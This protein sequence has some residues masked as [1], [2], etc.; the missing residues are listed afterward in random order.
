MATSAAMLP[1]ALP[2][3]ACQ[4]MDAPT[5]A[6][7][8][9]ASE[10]LSPSSA[11]AASQMTGSKL[12]TV[13]LNGGANSN[14]D[15]TLPQPFS[16]TSARI[17]SRSTSHRLQQ[18]HR[19]SVGSRSPASGERNLNT[20]RVK[21]QQQRQAQTPIIKTKSTTTSINKTSEEVRLLARPQV[22]A[23][24]NVTA[25]AP[26]ST[27]NTTSRLQETSRLSASSQRLSS[28]TA[29]LA[30]YNSNAKPQTKR[31]A[32][33]NHNPQQHQQQPSQLQKQP[34]HR[35]QYQSL[36]RLN[37]NS[38]DNTTELSQREQQKT[39]R[40]DHANQVAHNQQVTVE[41]PARSLKVN[42]ASSSPVSHTI[43]AQQRQTIAQPLPQ[44]ISHP[45]RPSKVS[46]ATLVLRSINSAAQSRQ[47]QEQKGPCVTNS[48]V[49]Q[50]ILFARR[51]RQQ[52]GSS[53]AT[54]IGVTDSSSENS[55]SVTATARATAITNTLA[56]RATAQSLCLATNT[57]KK[58]QITS[59]TRLCSTNRR[60]TLAKATNKPPRTTVTTTPESNSKSIVKDNAMIL[61]GSK[62]KSCNLNS[63][64]L[65]L[66]LPIAVKRVRQNSPPQVEI[67]IRRNGVSVTSHQQPPYSR[68]QTSIG[69]TTA[70][71][72]RNSHL[73]T[74]A[75]NKVNGVSIS[76]LVLTTQTPLPINESHTIKTKINNTKKIS[77]KRLGSC[78]DSEGSTSSSSCYSSEFESS[79]GR[80][81]R[82]VG[83]RIASSAERIGN[84]R[85]RRSR[86]I[87]SCDSNLSR[88]SSTSVSSIT[89]ASSYSNINQGHNFER[90]RGLTR[91]LSTGSLSAGSTQAVARTTTTTA[92]IV[93]NDNS[94]DGDSSSSNELRHAQA[95]EFRTSEQGDCAAVVAVAATA[96]DSERAGP[97]DEPSDN[98][99]T[100]NNTLVVGEGKIN[101]SNLARV[102]E[103]PITDNTLINLNHDRQSITTDK[104][105][106]N[107]DDIIIVDTTTTR[108]SASET[109]GVVRESNQI[110][111]KLVDIEI[112]CNAYDDNHVQPGDEI[113]TNAL[114]YKGNNFN[115]DCCDTSLE[116][117]EG[118]Q[119]SESK[120]IIVAASD[121]TNEQDKSISITEVEAKAS[122]K[123]EKEEDNNE[124]ISCRKD[125]CNKF[126]TT[127]LAVGQNIENQSNN[128]N[129]NMTVNRRRC[130]EITTGIINPIGL[131]KSVTKRRY[132]N[133]NVMQDDSS[134]SLSRS[135]PQDFPAAKKTSP[136]LRS[137]KPTTTSPKL[138]PLG[139]SQ[140]NNIDNLYQ[141]TIIG[142]SHNDEDQLKTQSHLPPQFETSK[143]EK[144]EQVFEDIQIITEPIS[145]YYHIEARPFARGKF[146]QVKRC[147]SRETKE[148]FA[149]KCIKKR[150][151]LVDIR[152]EILLEIEALKLSCYT[153]HIVK[154]YQ[155]FETQN[156]MILILE[157]AK[158]GE[159]QRVLDDEETIDELNVK[160]MVRQI[161]EGLVH[162]HDNEI[163]HLDIKPQNLLLTKSFP[164]GDIKLCDF[165][166]SRRISRDCEIREICGTPDYVAPEILRYDPISLATDMWS[167][168]VLTYV[169]LSGYSPFGSE[170]KQQTFCNITQAT[171]DFPE[172][173]FDK[174]SKDAID[175]MSKLIVREPENRLTSRQACSHPWLASAE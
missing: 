151:R 122:N 111:N 42:P 31:L 163:A 99:N 13:R 88:R 141:N 161:L 10:T 44:L 146:A 156:E 93:A 144:S 129:N 46:Q 153:K 61:P 80:N 169:L 18:H 72:S 170:N 54:K 84:Q 49:R 110:A 39:L 115:L 38:A 98:D 11:A 137:M 155:V 52:F 19:Q 101:T 90:S 65:S 96:F 107:S 126:D 62:L 21:R 85:R 174:I 94:S 78:D 74:R 157:M 114:D 133:S 9:R 117:E 147:V 59:S 143:L 67:D 33:L 17:A 89:S 82:L 139:P 60:S 50:G 45:Q 12:A 8:T 30:V 36:T 118:E 138:E 7:T 105:G 142:T 47:L 167:L 57:A 131:D 166:I 28:S 100:S 77:S 106:S 109:S 14:A 152:H 97:T 92:P 63:S 4:L 125:C 113:V 123:V 56:T 35:H 81:S 160:R 27:A 136:A 120:T 91:K 25:A 119:E 22:V 20:S 134:K 124:M 69:Q 76:S 87:D 15:V 41:G 150:R 68:N 70:T 172:E 3:P 112:E 103:I 55:A 102:N 34:N 73:S 86:S 58:S 135:P 2:M 108:E 95:H 48:R 64:S 173:I 37:Q 159:L 6:T 121:T 75:A 71:F 128:N 16:Q 23:L 132:S 149:A 127:K 40:Q 32:H 165:G 164:E 116:Q 43:F 66:S 162:L 171:L 104:I 158:G 83:A 1:S 148:C 168:G 130:S 140:A 154:L 145:D 51:H 5:S 79:G 26:T 29:S 175:F 24:T 53:P